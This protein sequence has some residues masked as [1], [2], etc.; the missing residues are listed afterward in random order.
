MNLQEFE[1][2]FSK[3]R[4]GYK[5]KDLDQFNKQLIKQQV[6]VSFLKD[7]VLT[8]QQ[9]HRTYFQVSLGQMKKIEEQLKFIED[10]FELLQD[11]WH[12]DQLTQ[13]LAKD[14]TFDYAF[15]KAQ[16]Y[17]KNDLP[18]A[19]RWGYVMFMPRLVKEEAGF[20]KLLPLFHEDEVY[21]V[22]MAEAWLISYMAMYHVEKTYDYIASRPL[23]YDIMGKAIQKICDSYRVSQ[24]DKE[25]FKELRKLWQIQSHI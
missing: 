16:E 24:E 5:T 18:Y 1:N 2:E 8:K 13:F 4:E 3:L 12:V 25:R 11:W 22:V 6:D 10:N 23:S 9:Y 17:V 7:I 19:R 15:S 14:F 20:D 21:H